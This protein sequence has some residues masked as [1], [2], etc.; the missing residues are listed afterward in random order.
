MAI[1]SP[2]PRPPVRRHYA[3]V[4]DAAACVALYS[5]LKP[6][7]EYCWAEWRVSWQLQALCVGVLGPAHE[8]QHVSHILHSIL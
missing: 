6:E 4:A 8:V 5:V 7:V 2:R 1:S 3:P